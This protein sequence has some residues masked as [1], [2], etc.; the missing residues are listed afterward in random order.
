MSRARRHSSSPV[1]L[2]PF[3]AVLVSALGALVLLLIAVNRHVS[4]QAR[5]EALQI[6]ERQTSA[7][8]AQLA[9]NSRE[10][11]QGV[12][13]LR[14]QID[15]T[16][17]ER[18]TVEWMLESGHRQS[19]SNTGRFEH[20]QHKMHQ[21]HESRAETEARIAAI[22][23]EIAAILSARQRLHSEL[24]RADRS[25]VPVVHPGANGTA[26]QPIYLECTARGIAI[27]PEG[28]GI[29]IALLE[30]EPGRLMLARAVQALT[31]YYLE[32]D[33]GKDAAH[34]YREW[35]PYPLLL[36]RPDGASLFYAAREILEDLTLPYG[37]E[38][39]EADW[40]LQFPKPDSNARAVALSALNSVRAVM[41]GGT[42]TPGI[43][44]GGF[45]RPGGDS[46]RYSLTP[47]LGRLLGLEPA[48]AAEDAPD[49]VVPKQPAIDRSPARPPYGNAGA[50]S[51][52]GA[53]SY[54]QSSHPLAAESGDG[55]SYIEGVAGPPGDRTSGSRSIPKT[56][57][58]SGHARGSERLTM[59]SADPSAADEGA[60]DPANATAQNSI[61]GATSGQAALSNSIAPAEMTGTSDPPPSPQAG[62]HP[63]ES[64]RPFEQSTTSSQPRRRGL[65][66][67]RNQ[68]S[69]ANSISD[70]PSAGES[71]PHL[72]IDRLDMTIPGGKIP[73]PREVEI[74]CRADG[75]IIR[76]RAIFLR[77]RNPTSLN[78]VLPALS[79]EL[80]AVM[81]SWGPAGMTFQWQ[82]KIV[83]LVHQDGLQMY[84]G[85]RQ[86]FI[87]SS[88]S[89]SHVVLLEDTIDWNETLFLHRL[90]QST[91]NAQRREE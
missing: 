34:A 65:L 73:I 87:G 89:I 18:Q 46:G 24:Q 3:L 22:R 81:A 76:D 9:G 56:T 52:A 64:R 40:H 68:L 42:S 21:V 83:C 74:D 27:Q 28:V 23:Q 10:L 36:V 35:Q 43:A 48:S 15:R 16:H 7:E 70:D 75:L 39:I 63:I 30:H 72:G 77:V 14:T 8:E 80:G 1:Q 71:V 53:S 2:F 55:Q 6:L 51:L 26:R 91:F 19:Q 17:I 45:G 84:Y 62:S 69:T 82:L 44:Q 58:G 78:D 13:A 66:A 49:R 47:K 31:Q 86:A 37:Y 57:S 88:V 11:E 20:L 38:L 50:D 61:A 29:S 25:F 12:A 5:A 60:R 79:E 4:I 67:S 54:G 32:R 33:V 59:E 41:A 90:Q 85:L